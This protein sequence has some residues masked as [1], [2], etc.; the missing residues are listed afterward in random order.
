MTARVLPLG[1]R[2]L[3]VEV[4]GAREVL[5]L[6]ERLREGSP[7][8]RAEP[9]G[10]GEG[11]VDPR[12]QPLELVPAAR[13]LMVRA[14]T[15]AG[16]PAARVAVEEALA[17]LPG[18]DGPGRSAESEIERPASDPVLI[19]VTYDGPDLAEVA[20]LT[21]LSPEE[22]VEAHTGADYTVAFIGFAPGFAYLVGGDPRLHVPRRDT[23]RASVPA[24]AVGL[25]GEFSG[26]YPRSSPGGWQL[27]GRT[28]T[29]L[30]DVRRDPPALLPPGTR[31]R[32]EAR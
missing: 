20:A 26:V 8:L 14:S 25:A 7:G 15:P 17:A 11:F 27:L 28:D 10:Q 9:V 29:V 4:D 12:E 32:F 23:P 30:W 13:T 19:T 31:V 24:G 2:A 21:G 16:L 1:E 22:V 5:A 3:L 18:G 6:A